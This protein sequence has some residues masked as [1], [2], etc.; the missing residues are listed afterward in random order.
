MPFTTA[1]NFGTFAKMTTYACIM[2][3]IS[4]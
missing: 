3:S 4:Q 2:V 1:L